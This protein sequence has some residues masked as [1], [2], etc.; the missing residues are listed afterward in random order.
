MQHV[1]VTA[2]MLTKFWLGN[3]N[4]RD[5]LYGPDVRGRIILKCVLMK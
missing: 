3:M 4:E 1:W 2:E 5:Y